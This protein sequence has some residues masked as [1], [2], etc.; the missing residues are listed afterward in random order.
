[1]L[2]QGAFQAEKKSR[3]AWAD[4]TDGDWDLL[5]VLFPGWAGDEFILEVRFLVFDER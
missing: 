2:R 5:T 3:R 4:E 1:M